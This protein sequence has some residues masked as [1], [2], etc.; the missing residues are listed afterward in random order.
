VVGIDQHLQHDPLKTTVHMNQRL[1]SPVLLCLECST[2][3]CLTI[4]H[5]NL[6]E[7]L[8]ARQITLPLE[9]AEMVLSG[10]LLWFLPVLSIQDKFIPLVT[11]F[12]LNKIQL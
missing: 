7:D 3:L 11:L 6:L 2:V 8:V 9:K 12:A 5:Q 10:N 4:R 1:R